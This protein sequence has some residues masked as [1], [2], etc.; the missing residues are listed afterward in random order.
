MNNLNA[1]LEASKK[2]HDA[3]IILET[4]FIYNSDGKLLYSPLVERRD[5]DIPAPSM[6][7]VW[8]ELP[9][10]YSTDTD[11]RLKTLM[12]YQAGYKALK[13]DVGVW[14]SYDTNPTDA[15]IDLLIF[16]RKEKP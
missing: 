15:L 10:T 7:E 5:G 4:D 13:D 2:L 11:V 14:F 16:V 1:S 12:S 8:R 6:A 3:G 9:N